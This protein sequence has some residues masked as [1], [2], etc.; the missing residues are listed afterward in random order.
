MGTSTWQRRWE[1]MF[2]CCTSLQGILLEQVRAKY[3]YI[4]ICIYFSLS[5][6]LYIYIYMYIQRCIIH[7]Y[8]AFANNRYGERHLR[9]HVLV[10]N[11]HLRKKATTSIHPK[12]QKNNIYLG[13]VKSALMQPNVPIRLNIALE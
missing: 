2:F 9:I 6:S 12:T 8:K 13:S 3:I 7:A 1:K 11:K 4:Y 10:F 5:L